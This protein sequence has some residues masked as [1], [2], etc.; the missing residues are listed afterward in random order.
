[1]VISTIQRL[2]AYLSDKNVN[3]DEE[4]DDSLNNYTADDVECGDAQL[5]AGD[6]AASQPRATHRQKETETE[7][8]RRRMWHCPRTPN[9]RPIILT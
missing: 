8:Q 5:N 6:N 3:D 4:D 9:C 2:F 7:N 1:M